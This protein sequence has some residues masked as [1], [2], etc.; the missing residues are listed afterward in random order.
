MT[1]QPPERHWLE[2][3][4]TIRRL[5][6]VFAVV[7][8]A[9]VALE[10]AVPMH[11]MF[12]VDGIFGFNAWYGFASCVALILIAKALGIFLSRPDRYYRD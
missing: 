8:A 4:R 12:G 6:I 7:L 1:I 10:L 9:T 11:G 2:R 3:P 5:W